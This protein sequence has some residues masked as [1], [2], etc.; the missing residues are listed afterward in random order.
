LQKGK[1]NSAFGIIPDL[2]IGG[3]NAK[4]PYWA[5]KLA[6]GEEVACEVVVIP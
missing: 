4:A 2:S 3:G 5:R 1:N 6:I